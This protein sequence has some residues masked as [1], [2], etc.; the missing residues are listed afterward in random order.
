[1]G[2]QGKQGPRGFPGERGAIGSPG[3]PGLRGEAGGP[4]L[5]GPPVSKLLNYLCDIAM[6]N[7]NIC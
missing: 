7:L 5:D 2:D 4:G 3:P 1:M 6:L